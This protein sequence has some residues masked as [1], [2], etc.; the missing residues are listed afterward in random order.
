MSMLKEYEKELKELE[1]IKPDIRNNDR[2]LYVQNVIERHKAELGLIPQPKEKK[3]VK[4][5]PKRV[6]R[7]IQHKL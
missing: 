1:D 7:P 5:A 3:E 4:Y 2:L 6:Y